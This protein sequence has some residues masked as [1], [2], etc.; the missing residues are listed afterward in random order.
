LTGAVF[1]LWL[2]RLRTPVAMDAV[3]QGGPDGR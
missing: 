1:S 2:S 3:D